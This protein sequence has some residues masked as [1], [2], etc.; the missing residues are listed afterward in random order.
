MEG[1][2]IHKVPHCIGADVSSVLRAKNQRAVMSKQV[3]EVL[4]KARLEIEKFL[5]IQLLDY[6]PNMY[7]AHRYNYL[8]PPNSATQNVPT[9]QGLIAW[10]V[11]AHAPEVK[12]QLRGKG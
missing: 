12:R 6:G 9:V 10:Q 8:V 2:C 5:A 7:P 4:G 3:D 11:F 1:R